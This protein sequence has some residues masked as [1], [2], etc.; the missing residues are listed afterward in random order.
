MKAFNKIFVFSTGLIA[1]LFCCCLF[2]QA[3]ENKSQC[4]DKKIGMITFNAEVPLRKDDLESAISI[5]EGDLFSLENL[6]L[7]IEKLKS[8]GIFED[9][10]TEISCPELVNVSFNLH[11]LPRIEEI[12]FKGYYAIDE[13]ELRRISEL[14]QGVVYDKELIDNAISKISNAYHRLGYYQVKIEAQ[15]YRRY[16]ESQLLIELEIDEGYQSRIEAI[17]IEGS[18]SE[19]LAY[20]KRDY[21]QDAIHTPASEEN[22]ENQRQQLL[23]KLRTENYIEASVELIG[24]EP[25]V[26]TGDFK[27]Y[28][29]VIT[30]KQITINIA[31]STIYTE[32]A[33]KDLLRLDTR[34]VPFT[35]V[36]LRSLC[37]QIKHKYQVDGYYY[38]DVDFQRLEETE[39]SIHYQIEITE[40]DKVHITSIVLRGNLSVSDSEL[41]NLMTTQ[42][43]GIFGLKWRYPGYLVSDI[44]ENDIENIEN[45]YRILGYADVEV[46]DNII[47]TDDEIILEVLIEEGARKEI[48]DIQVTGVS[49]QRA[50]EI[51][52]ILPTFK[53]HYSPREIPQIQG[54]IKHYLYALGHADSTIDINYDQA[55]KVLQ[56]NI[57]AG[58]QV[59]IGEI[60]IAGNIFTRDETIIKNLFIKTGDYWNPD[61]ID[62]SRQ[63][64]YQLGIF[65]YVAL[66][67]K[68][69]KVDSERENLLVTVRERDNL[70]VGFGTGID[71]ENGLQLSGEIGEQNLGGEADSLALA[72]E[73]YFK[74]AD[75]LI[76]AGRSRLS[77]LN[78]D[79]VD[80]GISQLIEAYAN[81]SVELFNEYSYD[82]IG[83]TMKLSNAI[84]EQIKFT[85]GIELF[86]ENVYD[87]EPDMIIGPHDSGNSTFG[88][89]E[90]GLVMDH[91]DDV[92][93]PRRGWLGSLDTGIAL[94]KLG[95]DTNYLSLLAKGNK[96]FELSDSVVWANG[97]RLEALRPY[98]NDK[99]I[100]LS[101]RLFLGGRSSVRGYS[102][103]SIS[104]SGE[105][106]DKIGGD[107]G[108]LLNSELQ[109]DI[110]SGIIGV[111]FVDAGAVSLIDKGTFSGNGLNIWDL[112]VSPGFGL[113]YRTPV[114]PIS[115]SWG[116]PINDSSQ[117]SLGHIS[118]G[119][120]YIF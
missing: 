59:K 40:G 46:R 48:L 30:G 68:D 56:I 82:K 93:N 71:S 22:I 1:G 114:G 65:N 42:E 111:L 49:L 38:A 20:L 62:K 37:Q 67:P 39:N 107:T 31:G 81:F 118:L 101:Q 109:I 88:I 25:Q 43:Q 66:A 53:G 90:A 105:L 61:L 60:I 112:K 117:Q 120:G 14:T 86:W 79:F 110:T 19:N 2:C 89:V 102:R 64:L 17:D 5:K 92:F 85:G 24:K 106:G 50:D 15:K 116:F 12:G 21:I 83:T 29:R 100:P 33:L 73:G 52:R 55:H 95:S 34:T 115:F 70:N 45:Y 77:Y 96:Y 76:D 103:N 11:I 63:R 28:F 35:A 23:T 10:T 4:N 8:R 57:N 3:E 47:K 74:S 32:D 91:R 41:I 6:A 36:A 69:G 26:L 99:V 51:Q 98:G 104:P 78:R 9:I 75:R 7:A 97:V 119:I 72:F 16:L 58:Q 113:N 80:T 87:V 18:I 94:D 84:A 44:W 13:S 54:Q 27:I 108:L